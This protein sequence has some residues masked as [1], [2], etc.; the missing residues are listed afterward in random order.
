M[1]ILTWP[2]RPHSRAYFH[3]FHL[4]APRSQGRKLHHLWHYENEEQAVTAA[5]PTVAP[6]RRLR[7]DR[8]PRHLSP[9]CTPPSIHPPPPDST[10]G[11]PM[12]VCELGVLQIHGLTWLTP[13]CLTLLTCLPSL[14]IQFS[15]LRPQKWTEISWAKLRWTKLRRA[16][17]DQAN[18]TELTSTDPSRAN[19]NSSIHTGKLNHCSLTFTVIHTGQ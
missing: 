11:P 3:A 18:W 5:S 9:L 17:L 1:Q 19:L 16:E 12:S 7:S 13:L 14:S 2:W 10:N 6:A 4:R 15:L 8:L